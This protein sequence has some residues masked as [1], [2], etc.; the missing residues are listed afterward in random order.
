MSNAESQDMYLTTQT[1]VFVVIRQFARGV[2]TLRHQ[3]GIDNFYVSSM[4]KEHI[5]SRELAAQLRQS[6]RVQ[7][8]S[9]RGIDGTVAVASRWH[10]RS[11]N[12]DVECAT[13]AR[14]LRSARSLRA[15]SRA[16][17]TRARA[18]T[19]GRG[20]ASKARPAAHTRRESLVV[21]AAGERPCIP[22]LKASRQN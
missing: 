15:P 18:L 9:G 10:Q 6:E 11:S 7:R 17:R 2:Y 8:G 16:R 5:E 3:V 4:C 21:Q 13:P 22:T 19:A 20:C 14:G 1:D 12:K